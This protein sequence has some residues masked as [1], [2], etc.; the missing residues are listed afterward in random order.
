MLFRS[1]WG[2][3]VELTVRYRKPIPIDGEVRAVGRITRDSSR[4]FEGRGEIV[5]DGVVAATARGKYLRLPLDEITDDGLDEL[6][7]FADP[8]GAPDS[9]DV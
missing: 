7:W 2:V 1:A 5:V 6:N 8:R 9:I 4:L 3:T